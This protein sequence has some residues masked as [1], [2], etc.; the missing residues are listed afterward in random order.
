MVLR[1]WKK[2]GLGGVLLIT[3]V[4][5]AWSNVARADA[6]PP[7]LAGAFAPEQLAS[8]AG[9]PMALYPDGLTFDVVRDG[10]VVGQHRT[11]FRRDGDALT[12]SARM[13]LTVKLLG[14]T[15]YR[16]A[17]QSSAEWRDGTLR[18]LTA[19]TD[20][21]GTVAR[22]TAREEGGVMR[23]DGPNGAARAEAPLFPTNHWHAGV[24]TRDQVLNTITGRIATVTITPGPIEQVGTGSGPRPARRFD[25]DG[26]IQVSSWYDAA[27]RWVKLRFQRG[28]STIEYRCR[29]CG[30]EDGPADHGAAV[31]LP[32]T[33]AARGAG[34]GAA[35]AT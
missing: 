17:Y 34:G 14:L 29:V 27:G 3:T 13:D 25:Y 15:L 8:R 35:W 2:G 11:T 18:S 10:S 30:A 26:A 24:L 7:S 12:V 32:T 21:D 9:T 33:V 19:V 22:V 4:L 6:G 5:A 16:F 31:P 20:D 28:G 23:V 1:S